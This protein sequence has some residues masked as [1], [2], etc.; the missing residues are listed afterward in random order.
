MRVAQYSSLFAVILLFAAVLQVGRAITGVPMTFGQAALPL[1]LGWG[2]C[3]VAI[4]AACLGYTASKSRLR[5]ARLFERRPG[6]QAS[7][8]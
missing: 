7:K 2:A 4:I 8:R 5:R 6:S 1:W 3:G